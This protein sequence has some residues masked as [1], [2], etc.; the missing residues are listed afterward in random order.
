ML[1]S[2]S[3]L[4]ACVRTMGHK[5]TRPALCLLCLLAAWPAA[6][7]WRAQAVMLTALRAS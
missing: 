3:V 5:R 2:M 7:I 1:Q 6:A 4:L